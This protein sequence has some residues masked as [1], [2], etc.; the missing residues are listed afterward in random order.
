MESA[1]SISR[2]IYM[3][4]VFRAHKT[5]RGEEE[6]RSEPRQLVITLC[7]EHC[8]PSSSY[9][10]A[11]AHLHLLLDRWPAFLALDSHFFDGD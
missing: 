11:P 2:D 7:S 10:K 6:D 8:V 3:R 5:R 9:L 1:N 4:Q